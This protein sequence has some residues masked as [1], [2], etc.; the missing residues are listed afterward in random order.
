MA[1]EL[2]LATDTVQRAYPYPPV[3]VAERSR[4]CDSMRLMGE[5]TPG[6]VLVI[7]DDQRLVG[8][9]TE[10]DLLKLMAEG[11]GLDGPIA[12][13]MSRL[14]VTV[15]VAEGVGTAVRIMSDGGYRRLPVID[16][17]GRP[18]GIL[19][20]ANILHYLV[21]HFPEYVY[22]LPPEPGRSMHE[23]EGA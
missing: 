20:V 1:F 9:F 23:R 15:G 11:T 18:V 16:H 17:D 3:C 22:N 13:V 8:I 21:E 2:H 10:R 12:D 5:G 6:C 19:S 7:D 4:V 14:P